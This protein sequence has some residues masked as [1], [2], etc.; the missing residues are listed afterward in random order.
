[1]SVAS[2]ISPGS[3]PYGSRLRQRCGECLNGCGGAWLSSAAA[4]MTVT[5]T[6]TTDRAVTARSVTAH[7]GGQRHG[8]SAGNGRWEAESR[9][10]Q[11]A[12]LLISAP[13]FGGPNPEITVVRACPSITDLVV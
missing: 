8:G 5:P 1:M 9:S 3:R 13:A 10:P 12:A 6:A 7:D 4:G 2:D 11:R